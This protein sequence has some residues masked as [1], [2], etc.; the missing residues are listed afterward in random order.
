MAALSNFFRPRDR[1]PAPTVYRPVR[2]NEIEAAL[3]LILGGA[4]P[5][6]D[7]Q[8]LDFLSFSIGRG[9]DVNGIWVADCAG[10]IDWALLPV[11]SAGRTMLLFSPAR[12]PRGVPRSAVGELVERVLAA[13]AA[14][15]GVVLAQVLLEAHE[16]DLISRYVSAGFERLAD[17][18]YLQA[19]VRGTE[20]LPALPDGWRIDTY[21]VAGHAQF[22]QTIA[23]TYEGSLDCPTL[24]GRREI[25]D[26][27]AGHKA[28][29]DFDPRLWFL[30]R[31]DDGRPAGVLL[32]SRSHGNAQVELVYV[33]LVPDA[34]G[35]GAGDLLIRWALA[36]TGLEGRRY[37]SLAV[38]AANTPALRL[39][40]RH[41]FARVGVRTALIRDLRLA[42]PRASEPSGS[43]TTGVVAPSLVAE[44]PARG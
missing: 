14:P 25:D 9:I 1:N 26:I 15:A 28:A 43:P 30:L 13:S 21:D 22:A 44:P 38:D 32:L 19:R 5:A 12:A 31:R 27:V 11:P 18:A 2:R 7:E 4:K 16:T 10:R 20:P 24:N 8:V 41:G 39:Y 34:R 3:R 6:T 37:L 40:F 35:R 29:G 33:G 42:P 17:L 36:V 23:E